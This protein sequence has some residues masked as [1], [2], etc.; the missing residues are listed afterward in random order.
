M[1][2]SRDLIVWIV[3]VV[4]ILTSLFTVWFLLSRQNNISLELRSFQQTISNIKPV[5]GK[6]VTLEQVA[7]AV[8]E[9]C[10]QQK[11]CIGLRGADSTVPGPKGE[12][13]KVPG[14]KGPAS[15]VPGPRGP[16]GLTGP[17]G[18]MGVAGPEGSIGPQGRTMEE[19]CTVVNPE[20]R[21]IEW[22]YTD[23]E[24]WEP[25][26][27]LAPGQLCPQEVEEEPQ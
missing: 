8:A 16:V 14:P 13:S 5:N 3:L 24:T 2:H 17:I 21:R 15:N 23:V 9:Y 6:D 18:L 11:N 27:Y 26:Y 20:K 10:Q 1:K 12:P 7:Q 4:S 19:R 22:K 25:K